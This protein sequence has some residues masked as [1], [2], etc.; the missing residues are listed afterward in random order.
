MVKVTF[1]EWSQMIIDNFEKRFWIS[2]T[3]DPEREEAPELINRRA[4]Y[5]DVYKGSQF[6][7]DTQ[8]RP[9]FCV[10]MA[11]VSLVASYCHTW[12]PNA[13]QVQILNDSFSEWNTVCILMK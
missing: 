5:K 6:W 7:A 11:V 1:S 4:I 8:L 13:L 12:I 9:N 3:P 10:T 2:E